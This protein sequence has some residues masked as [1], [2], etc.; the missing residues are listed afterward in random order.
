MKHNIAAFGGDADNITIMGQSAGAM[1]VQRHSMSPLSEG[2]FHKAVMSSGGGLNKLLGAASAEKQY[3]FWQAAM[4]N[5]GCATFADFRAISPER[6]FA[7]WQETKKTVKG[8][9]CFPCVDGVLVRENAAAMDIPYMAGSNSEDMMPPIL[10]AM[11][12][13]WCAG[14][15]TSSFCWYFDRQLPGDDKGAWHSA[16][17]WYWFG[18]LENCWRPM[19]DRDYALS[20]EMT[21][22]LCAFAKTGSPNLSGR[23]QWDETAAEKKALCFGE[24][25]THMGEPS[26]LRL[27]KTMLTNKNVGE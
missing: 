6:L 26:I 3:P 9:G 20:D 14:R 16:D 10:F 23:C 2:L 5:A 24:T 15:N 25:E 21:D 13:R 27:V 17:L 7:V 1:S 18:T 11:A 12:R 19:S 4:K 22:R 8:G